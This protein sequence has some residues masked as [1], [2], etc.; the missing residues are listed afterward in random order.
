M[1]TPAKN[2]RNIMALEVIKNKSEGMTIIDACDKVGMPRSTFYYIISN[3]PEYF[4]DIQQKIRESEIIELGMILSSKLN[5]TAKLIQDL[6]APDTNP[7]DRL[8]IFIALEK[9][10]DELYKQVMAHSKGNDQRTKEILTGPIRQ[11]MQSNITQAETIGQS[12]L[13]DELWTK[14]D[15]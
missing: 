11:H 14:L 15:K 4:I 6:L 1:D 8:K 7:R 10:I 5:T 3:H 9:R 13:P 2:A 12:S